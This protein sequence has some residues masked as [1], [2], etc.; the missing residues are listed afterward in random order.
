[1]TGP[2]HIWTVSFEYKAK[3]DYVEWE[4][5]DDLEFK[6]RDDARKFVAKMKSRKSMKERNLRAVHYKRMGT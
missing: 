2:R 1:M 6:T 3:G 4:M 5:W